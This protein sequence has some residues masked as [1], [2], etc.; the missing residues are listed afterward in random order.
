MIE[1]CAAMAGMIPIGDPMLETTIMGPVINEA[2]CTR[3]MG[4]IEQARDEKQG[5]I[6]AGGER[7][8][9]D[10]ADGYFIGLTVFAD[11]DNGSSLAQ[12]EI[13]G[14]VVAL[15]P[16][17][18]EEEAIGL[19][20]DTEYG[21]A[22]YIHTNDLGRVHR[23]ADQLVAGN[24]WVNQFFGIASSV[25]FGGTKQSGFGRLGGLAGVK[26]FM[27]PKNVWIGL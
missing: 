3:I 8:G 21:L 26:E 22:G 11:V 18:T 24:I 17:D 13:F 23:V 6:V 27:R 4:V 19:A 25:P 12:N 7:L 1:R 5:R 2:A 15:I 16:F 14:P 10:L 20:N 9:G